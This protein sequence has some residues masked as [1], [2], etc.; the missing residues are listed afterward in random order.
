MAATTYS[1]VINLQ[2]GG[3]GISAI[4]N[5]ILMECRDLAARRLREA[6][7][8]IVQKV[9]EDL[10][11]RADTA[12]G[13][14]DRRFLLGLKDALS[15][16]GGRLEGQFAAHWAREFDTALKGISVTAPAEILLEEMQIVEYGEMDEEL[17]LKALAHRLHTTFEDELYALGR[18][19]NYLLGKE[20]PADGGNP[21]APEVLTR[22]LQGALRAMDFDTQNR[23]E[24]CRGLEGYTA[25]HIGPIY[26]A[27][28]AQLLKHNV[29][30]NVRRDY[31]RRSGEVSSKQTTKDSASG[32]M[33]AMLQRLVTGTATA[34]DAAP[35][36]GVPGGSF[37]V[38]DAGTTDGL[39]GSG[40]RSIPASRLWAS[41]ETLQHAVPGMVIGQPTATD[42]VNVLH[43]FRA[44]EVGQGLGQLDAITV[45]IVAML[46]DMIFDDREIGD[47]IKALVGRLQIPVLK[48]A[49]LDRSFF[50]TKAHPTRR[51]LD[52]ISQSALRW[53]RQVGHDDPIY[54]KVAEI[55]DHIHRNF[56]Q[57][58]ALFGKLCDDLE[59][60]LAEQETAATG[61][62]SR[63][64]LLVVQRE[65]D[66]L[67]DMTVA[68]ELQT[69]LNLPLPQAISDLLNHEW[70]ALLK[71]THLDDGPDSEAW[72][73]ALKTASDLVESATP[74]RDTQN[75]QTLVRQLPII[76]KQLSA[77]FDRIGVNGERR[78]ALLDR[79]FSLHA[80]ALRGSEVPPKVN[81]TAPESDTTPVIGET[82]VISQALGD[83]EV[84]VESISLKA[85]MTSLVTCQDVEQLQRGAWVEFVQPDAT[86]IRYRLSWI[87]PQRGIFL[88]TNP[89]SPHA[90]AVS[91]E[92]MSLQLQLGKVRIL[93]TVPIFDRALTR[94]IEI[95]Q[96]A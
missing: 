74:K 30:P 28:N 77:G 96:A 66:E 46:F 21:A 72:K 81:D 40:G 42:G 24:I 17:A 15:E 34:S 9:G 57:D 33:F 91:P 12:T 36:V 59:R 67:A 73:S 48:V 71:R 29:L 86:T 10:G 19:F 84:T 13:T 25:D 80:N 22:A 92:A 60:F 16:K 26:H 54:R 94:T 95:L 90:L 52:L 87:S 85:P 64:A 63:A 43:D 75:R 69:W 82:S 70:R 41:L 55:I 79:L 6:L 39:A 38:N 23:L 31:G 88:F 27:I 32:D 58:T 3:P 11:Q 62:V 45:D 14:N 37:N 83:G 20:N 89:Q 51:L 2:P 68:S 78:H 61:N 65:L 35:M 7:R 5:R 76:L 1:N 4:S 47:P 53:G 56:Q 18:R 50:S 93:P 8:E 49:M 44:S